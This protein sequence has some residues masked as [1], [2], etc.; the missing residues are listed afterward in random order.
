AYTLGE[1]KDARAGKALGEVALKFTDNRFMIA[2]VLSSLTPDNLHGV[3][4]TVLGDKQ[5]AEPPAELLEQLVSVASAFEDDRTL[6]MALARIG[7]A[8]SG[9]YAAWQMTAVAGLLDALARREAAWEKY[10][11]SGELGKMFTFA[12]A[13]VVDADADDEARLRAI[14]LLGRSEAERG[15]DIE[16]LVALLVPQSSGA[17]QASSVEAL[18]RIDD[19]RVP[20][21]LLAGWKSH[22]P[23]LRSAILDALLSRDAWAETLLSAIESGAVGAGD[24]D[25]SR[26]QRLS[27]SENEDIKERAA[28]LLAGTIESNRQ[29]VFEQHQSVLT[30]Q[31]DVIAGAA[32]FNKRCSVCHKLRGVGHDVGPNLASLTDYSPPALLAALL[33]PNRAVE[34]KYLD[35]LAITASGQSYTGMLANETG[36]SVTLL[37]QEGKQQTIL[38]SELE[39]LQATGKSLMPEGLEK[40]VTPQEMANVIA[41]LRGSGA[42]RKTFEANRPQLVTPTA[43]GALQLYPTNCEIYGPTIVMEQLF[44]NL[45]KWEGENDRVVWNINVPKAG[46]YAVWLNYS[47]TDEAAGN[48]WL[49]EAGEHKLTG[50]ITATGSKDRY[51]EIEVGSID[52]AAGEQ[53][54]VLHSGGPIKVNLMQFGGLVLRPAPTPAK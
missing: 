9:D 32:V 4:A 30:M 48:T 39:A 10:D 31:G 49:L 51:Q 2:A 37:G 38:R 47:S 42:P 11:A 21:S 20:D 17:V 6:G 3:V 50:K 23:E 22:G 5:G 28:K 46:R 52:L 26:R 15:S 24:V 40:D 53:Q 36:N 1:W 18:A 8:D 33:D 14:R 44:K 34:A 19:P 43:A 25:A 13:T 27:R 16:S 54:L 12:R 41:Y 35:Y 29:Q 7:R 45:G